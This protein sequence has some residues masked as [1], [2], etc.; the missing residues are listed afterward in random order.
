MRDQVD[1]VGA[2]P[3]RVDRREVL[4]DVE[5]AQAAVAGD[6]RGHALGQVVAV[7]PLRRLG[8]PRIGVRVQVD[9]PGRDDRATR[10]R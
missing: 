1:D 7:Q 3:V 8:D 9:E 6:D 5:H 4:G 10:R 2:G